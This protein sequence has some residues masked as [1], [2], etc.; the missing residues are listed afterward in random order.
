MLKLIQSKLRCG[1]ISISGSKCN[2]FIND[3]AS[4]ISVVLPIFNHVMLNSTKYFQFLIFSKAVALIIDKTHLTPQG[5][6]LMIKYYTEMK[7]CVSQTTF[8]SRNNI[9]ITDY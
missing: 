6:L 4:L 9:F 5:R 2:Y 7:E 3:R 8:P 1:R